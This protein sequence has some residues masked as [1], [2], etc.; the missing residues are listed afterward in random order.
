MMSFLFVSPTNTVSSYAGFKVVLNISTYNNINKTSTY[1]LQVL[2]ELN[3]DLLT[4]F[5]LFNFTCILC[6]RIHTRGGPKNNWN[7]EYVRVDIMVG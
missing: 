5:M 1:T 2:R 6:N 3:T 7:N 4:C